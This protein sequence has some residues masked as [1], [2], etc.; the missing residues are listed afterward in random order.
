MPRG[1]RA[2][3]FRCGEVKGPENSGA[4]DRELTRGAFF[5][6]LGV[7]ARLVQPLYILVITW[8]WGPA[9]SGVY[10]LGHSLV[11]VI[12]GVIVTGYTDA[13]TIFGSRHADKA[14][15]DEAHR[16]ALYRIFGNAFTVS[17]GL[18]FLAALVAQMAGRTAIEN[19]FPRYR[20]L[21]PGVYFLAWSLVPRS[22]SQMAIAATKATMHMHHD[23]LV[24]GVVQ[25]LG[26]LAACFLTYGLG[27][28]LTMLLA[29]QFVVDCV[30]CGLALR[31]FSRHFSLA[32]LGRALRAFRF[33]RDMLSFA[34]P[35]SLN[36]TF[37]RY[38][39]RLDGIMLASFGLSEAELGYFSTAALL[40][41]NIAQI[42]LV[43]SG[44][45]APVA[46]RY[47]AS[48]ERQAFSAALG[49]VSRWTTSL[50]VPAVLLSV[51][52][53]EDV[54]RLV[55]RSYGH[56]SLFVAVLLIPPLTNCAYGMA[57]ACLM[58]TGH[59]RVTLA[60][61]FSV[62]ILNTL[63]TYLLIPRY[64][65]LGAAVA[66]ALATTMTT[67][68][69]MIE[70]SRIEDVRISWAAVWKPH[71]GFLAGLVVIALLWDPVSLPLAGRIGLSLAVLLGYGALMVI[72]DHEELTAVRRALRM[73]RGRTLGS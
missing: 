8:F 13:T 55:S 34:V 41:S 66:T 9:F 18:A 40:T 46:A 21:L 12:S 72:L 24:N 71:V 38:I 16:A 2:S 69:Q 64:G 59:S 56:D 37:N 60:N 65:M 14:T 58:F 73:V 29:A 10:L 23:A 19:V 25:P 5:N 50:V 57:G 54:L 53:R 6:V 7:V 26:M 70:L 1:A 44:A 49:R 67:V 11:E 33:D 20:E 61:S 63:F 52:L 36:L 28:G 4:Y 22:A 51:I 31:A 39:A 27:G 3:L 32:E 45:M 43:F 42:R 62:A 47:H 30:V 15:G 68:L 17:V 35:Q 48:G